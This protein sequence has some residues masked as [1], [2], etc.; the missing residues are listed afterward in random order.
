MVVPMKR[1]IASLL[2]LFGCDD[3]NLIRVDGKLEIP[4]LVD[5]GDVQ[6]G[7]EKRA[8]IDIENGGGGRVVV[9]SVDPDLTFSGDRYEFGVERA[10]FTV[11]PGEVA[12]LDVTFRPFV[13]EELPFESK[14]VIM[15]DGQPMTVIVRGRGVE[16]GLIVTPNPVDFGSVLIGATKEMEV[17]VTNALSETVRVTTKVAGGAVDVEEAAGVHHFR[18]NAAPAVDGLIAELAPGASTTIPVEYAPLA[19]DQPD[20]GRFELSNCE[21]DL[22]KVSVVLVGRG[23]STGLECAPASLDFGTVHPGVTRRLRTSCQNVAGAEVTVVAASLT[24]ATAAEYVL[25]P[26]ALPATLASGASID[27]DVDYTPTQATYDSGATPVGAIEIESMDATGYG[28]DPVQV[29]LSGKAGGPSLEVLPAALDFGMIALGTSHT[30]RLLVVNNGYENLVVGNVE[31]DA[32]GTGAFRVDQTSFVVMSGDAATLEVTFAPQLEGQVTSTLIL[33]TNDAVNEMFAVPLRGEGV[34]LPPCAHQVV[35]SMLSFG[36]VPLNETP[37]QSVAIENVGTDDCLLN[38]IAFVEPALGPNP[39]ELVNGPETAIFVAPG[40]SHDI[41]V[42]YV[43]TRIGTDMATIGFYVNDPRDSNPEI[44]VVGVGE[45]LLEIQCPA[46]VTTAVGTPVTLNTTAQVAGANITGYQWTI[47][48]APAGG[49]GTPNQWTPDP[50]VAASETFLPYI[51]GTYDILVEVFDDQGRTSACT[52]QVNAQGQGLVVTLTWNGSGDVDLHVH[53]S[54]PTPWFGSTDDCYYANRTP[55]WDAAFPNSQGPNPELDFDNVVSNGPEN[56]RVSTVVLNQPYTI[57][58]HNYSSAAGR[59]ATIDIF[60]GGVLMPT[61][62][63]MSSPLQG[64]A[65]GQCTGND[66]WK[67][68][69][70]TFT[71]PSQCVVSPINTTTPSTQACMSF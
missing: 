9:R 3:E 43:P 49:I 2:I 12:R 6:V 44:P 10:G 66:F 71:S 28:L 5:F 64:S 25:A 19:A 30:K 38:D 68:A 45:T 14:L 20:R 23:T 62:T 17:T 29:A 15:A 58:V 53:N 22:C 26:P 63:A 34:D 37:V 33:S 39:F 67:V 13:A 52:T 31:A 61:Y 24:A 60:C 36:A 54:S 1:S 27:L 69:T 11:Q 32:A 56:T 65:G 16:S 8:R 21:S 7:L 41:P 48:N 47:G 51:V 50:P 59:V 46:P 42:R 40:T 35:P 57:G 55:Q 18:V 70:V 4:D